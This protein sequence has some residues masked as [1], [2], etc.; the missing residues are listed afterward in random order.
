[1]RDSVDG[2]SVRSS[3]RGLVVGYDELTRHIGALERELRDQQPSLRPAADDDPR[4]CLGARL[5]DRCGDRGHQPLP[6]TAPAYRVHGTLSS[7]VSVPRARS[8]RPP[9]EARPALLALGPAGSRDPR[10]PSSRLSRSLPADEAAARQ[11][12]WAIGEMSYARRRHL[13]RAP[14]RP[15]ARCCPLP[16]DP[17]SW[18]EVSQPCPKPPSLQNATTRCL[19]SEADPSRGRAGSSADWIRL[20]RVPPPQPPRRATTTRATWL[21]R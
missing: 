7:G 4:H 2:V 6:I 10:L 8:P 20:P 15:C 21:P 1:M 5:H 11:A 19:V 14:D 18:R 13:T 3:L 9:L 17:P 16:P 12:A